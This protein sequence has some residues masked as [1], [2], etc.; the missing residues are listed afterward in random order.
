[1]L[2]FIVHTKTA[3]A[4]SCNSTTHLG[5]SQNKKGR[6]RTWNYTS[7]LF[8]H[9]FSETGYKFLTQIYISS[10]L[11]QLF[12][13]LLPQACLVALPGM[14]LK[15][16]WDNRLSHNS[17]RDRFPAAHNS[18]W[19]GSKLT[20]P[21]CTPDFSETAPRHDSSSQTTELP[22]SSPRAVSQPSPP[23]LME[24]TSLA[25]KVLLSSLENFITP[26]VSNFWRIHWHCS[27]SLMNMYSR[28]TC[29]Q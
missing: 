1:M 29:W 13:G 20:T 11:K 5:P 15:A 3:A 21:T 18:L 17:D 16:F 8:W 25:S 24:R 28:P 9:L 6:N 7:T 4:K 26:G 12:P 10:V 23:H 22:G 19:Y 2:S 27:T 14:P